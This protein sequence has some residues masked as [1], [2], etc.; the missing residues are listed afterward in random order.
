MSLH[1]ITSGTGQ[2]DRG[3]VNKKLSISCLNTMPGFTYSAAAPT[4][5]ISISALIIFR[6][7]QREMEIRCQRAGACFGEIKV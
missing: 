1:K 6:R 3:I 4:S 2:R 5:A 7:I